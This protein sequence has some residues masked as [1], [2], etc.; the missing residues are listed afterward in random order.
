MA[1]ENL[2]RMR[3]ICQ[4]VGALAAPW[5]LQGD[6]NNAPELL[7][8]SGWFELARSCPLVPNNVEFTCDVGE[9]MID[10]L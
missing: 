6:F 4:F 8:D 5:I 3:D 7:A 10:F 9:A 1:G 2:N